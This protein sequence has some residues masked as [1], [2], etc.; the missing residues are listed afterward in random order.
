[1][2]TMKLL[3]MI[4]QTQWV[5]PEQCESVA[6]LYGRQKYNKLKIQNQLL[7]AFDAD[8]MVSTVWRQLARNV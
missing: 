7:K 5:T 4:F 1:M 6:V 3:E 2:T 8:E